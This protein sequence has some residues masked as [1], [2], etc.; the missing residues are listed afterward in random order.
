MRFKRPTKIDHGLT[1]IDLV[2]FINIIFLVLTF[3]LLL[4]SFSFQS[5]MTIKLP[6]TI[7]SDVIKDENLI[8][9][10]N[11]EDII[12]FNGKV[13]TVKELQVELSKYTLSTHS[14]LIKAD[15]RASLGRLVDVWD[16]CRGLNIEKINIAAD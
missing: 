6:K 7:T 4:S 1:V 10:V 5:G 14:I 11:S 8:I 16:L 13:L 3:L 2:P 12:S 9:I 15:R